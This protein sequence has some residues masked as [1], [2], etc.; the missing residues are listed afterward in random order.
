MGIF[1]LLLRRTA[2]PPKEERPA[3]RYPDFIDDAGMLLERLSGQ[4]RKNTKVLH[5]LAAI[6]RMKNDA[7]RAEAYWR[8]VLELDPDDKVAYFN[9]GYLH[10]EKGGERGEGRGP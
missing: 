5:C 10:S 3:P 7:K 1:A 9:L 6:A 2:A 4:L 8:R